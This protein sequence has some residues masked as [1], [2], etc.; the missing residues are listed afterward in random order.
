MLDTVNEIKLLSIVL[1]LR[2]EP[3]VKQRGDTKVG[4]PRKL[5]PR[6]KLFLISLSDIQVKSGQSDS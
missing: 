1:L 3:A 6:R 2:L 4:L 5:R